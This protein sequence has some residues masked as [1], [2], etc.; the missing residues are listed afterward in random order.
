MVDEN[1]EFVP[2]NDVN[3]KRDVLLATISLVPHYFEVNC[4]ELKFTNTYFRWR[5]SVT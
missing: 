3:E 2:P 4:N 1:L 5:T